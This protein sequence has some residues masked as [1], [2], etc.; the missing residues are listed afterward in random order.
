MILTITVN[1]S[2]DRA[3]FVDGLAVGDTN[4]VV[5][6]EIDAGGKGVNLARVAAELGAETLATGFLGGGAG[7]FVRHVLDAQGVRHEFIEVAGETRVNI[8]VEDGSG[9]PTT[10]NERGPEVPAA[11][12]E[13]LLDLVASRSKTADWVAMGGS[14]PPGLPPDAFRQLARAAGAGKVVLDTDGE[15]LDRA[16]DLG[17]ALV[18]PN[19]R[20]AS[21][22]LNSQI[23]SREEAL[24]AARE[25]IKRG[26]RSVI[27]SMGE[28]GAVLVCP[29]G[30]YFGLS[31]AVQARSTVGSGDSML[32]G[33][34]A[35]LVSGA[36]WPEAF[37]LGLAAGAATAMTDGSEIARR[38]VVARLLPEARVERV[39]V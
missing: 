4:R 37:R 13:Q 2:V 25:I 27:V 20:E 16:L 35:S 9:P 7:A 21:R 8:S 10:L 31:P 1:P 34:L 14:I 26:P 23:G 11:C 15:N 38:E 30:E 3:L 29:A 17:P 32:G 18:K 19:V 5:R 24:A 39:A 22:L 6:T 33:L 36:D 12:W 28:Q